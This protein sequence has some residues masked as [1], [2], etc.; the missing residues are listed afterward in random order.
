MEFKNNLLSL[1]LFIYFFIFP[2]SFPFFFVHSL[3]NFLESNATYKIQFDYTFGSMHNFSRNI[4]FLKGVFLAFRSGYWG[5]I[6]IERCFFDKFTIVIIIFFGLVNCW[7]L[8]HFVVIRITLIVK[9][10]YL[11]IYLFIFT[12]ANVWFS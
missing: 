5:S 9:S 11:F 6:I 10:Y 1:N 7:I 2:S 12:Y 8:I 4:T 3:L